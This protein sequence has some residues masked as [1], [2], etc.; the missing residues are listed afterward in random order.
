MSATLTDTPPGPTDEH[1]FDVRTRRRW[2]WILGAIIVVL[3]I[4]AALIVPRFIGTTS[5]NLVEGATLTIVTAE[6]NASEQALVEFVAEEV[7]PKYGITVD[8]KGLAD[9]TTLNRAVSEGEVAG[10]IYQHKLWLGQVLDANPDVTSK[11]GLFKKVWADQYAGIIEYR[12]QH[13]AVAVDGAS[14]TVKF[15]VQS[16]VRADVLNVLPSMRA[17][18]SRLAGMRV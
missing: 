3:G 4:A 1:G 13:K 2:P 11:P 10:T 12:P 15:E 9:S 16:D 5:P 7:A 6:G 14:R 8:F 17:E 18:S